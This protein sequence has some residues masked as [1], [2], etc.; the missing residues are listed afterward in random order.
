MLI[1]LINISGM[2][3]PLWNLMSSWHKIK[4]LLGEQIVKCALTWLVPEF[5]GAWKD[6]GRSLGQL[7]PFIAWDYAPEEVVNPGKLTCHL[8][9]GGLTYPSENQ[10]LLA[11][12]WGLVCACGPTVQYSQSVRAR[13]PFKWD[14]VNFLGK[15]KIADEHFQC[16]RELVIL[17]AI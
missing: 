5:Q 9:E 1:L 17:Q 12:Y 15:W 16:L 14:T 10:Q 7:S 13:Y 4:Q 11:L 8:I 3:W 6:L 2:L